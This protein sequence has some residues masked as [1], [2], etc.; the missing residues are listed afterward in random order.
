MV[1]KAKALILE[2][3]ETLSAFYKEDSILVPT[4][5]QRLQDVP[6]REAQRT[7]Y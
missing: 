5:Q 3:N 4:E 1:M 6:D 7:C 2:K